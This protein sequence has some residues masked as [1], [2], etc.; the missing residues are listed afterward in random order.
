MSPSV[1]EPPLCPSAGLF[2]PMTL[3]HGSG[4]ETEPSQF[5]LHTDTAR[6]SEVGQGCGFQAPG[7]STH[8][9]LDPILLPVWSHHSFSGSQDLPQGQLAPLVLSGRLTTHST[10]TCVLNITPL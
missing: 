5:T 8:F 6:V 2:P 3:T 4:H 10:P 1:K 7:S 9:P